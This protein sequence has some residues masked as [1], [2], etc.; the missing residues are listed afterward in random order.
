[1]MFEEY[2]KDVHQQRIDDGQLVNFCNN[3]DLER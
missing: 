1:M 2:V 3:N